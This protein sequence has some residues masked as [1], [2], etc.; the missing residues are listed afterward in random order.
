MSPAADCKEVTQGE[1][2]EVHE[3]FIKMDRKYFS[4]IQ[5]VQCNN[6]YIIKLTSL[7][8][9]SSFASL[10]KHTDIFICNLFRFKFV[11]KSAAVLFKIF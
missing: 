4:F 11:G 5:N 2:Q 1:D 10:A 6:K 7:L 3:I 8:H 9:F